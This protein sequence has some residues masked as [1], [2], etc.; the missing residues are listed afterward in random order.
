MNIA[1]I[2]IIDLC[3]RT[4]IGTN[5]WERKRRQRILI[6]ISFEF[7][8][9][10]AIRTDSLADTVDY[11]TLKRKIITLAE[12]SRFH[13]L[14]VLTQRILALILGTPGVLSARVRIEKPR[15]LRFA[16][17]VAVEMAQAQASA[18]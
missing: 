3:L 16:K 12:G 15:A 14:E 5:P 17:S 18:S 10:E 7:D 4:I 2:H 11:K 13:L 9:G 8:A 6:N 1:T